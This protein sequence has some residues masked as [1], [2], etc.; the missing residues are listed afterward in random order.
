[1]ADVNDVDALMN[2]IGKRA[3]AAARGLALAPTA[4]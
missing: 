2:E 4:A 1:M 3:R